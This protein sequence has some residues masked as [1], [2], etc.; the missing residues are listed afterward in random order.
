M[1]RSID[2]TYCTNV[3]ALGTPVRARLVAVYALSGAYAGVA[4]ALL[5]QTTQFVSLDTLSFQRSADGLLMLVL[6]GL[7]SLYGGL[8]G[9]AAFTVA[10]HLGVKL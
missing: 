9:A 2:L 6:G 3:H 5:A 8:L 1:T 4:G 7:G 10:H